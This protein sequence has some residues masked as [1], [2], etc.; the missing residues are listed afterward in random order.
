METQEWSDELCYKP[1]E[2]FWGRWREFRL[3]GPDVLKFNGQKRRL[4]LVGGQGP[5]LRSKEEAEDSCAVLCD[6][7]AGME[8]LRG[9]DRAQSHVVAH[10]D[11]DD[12]CPHCQ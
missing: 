6:E 4:D 7:H 1:A 5:R 9:N 2:S 3:P 8:V 10:E 12:M 11:M